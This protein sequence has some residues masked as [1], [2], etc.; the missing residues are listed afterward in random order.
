MQKTTTINDELLA[1]NRY[2]MQKIKIVKVIK[3][4]IDYYFVT[5]TV[6]Y[7]VIN[8]HNHTLQKNYN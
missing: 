6:K 2:D 7:F 4:I 5:V 3:I 8:G 1:I